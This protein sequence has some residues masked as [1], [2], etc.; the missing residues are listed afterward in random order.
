ME[1]NDF[2]ETAPG[3]V[4]AVNGPRQQREDIRIIR[5]PIRKTDRRLDRS[6]NAEGEYQDS[7][8][9]THAP[10]CDGSQGPLPLSRLVFVPRK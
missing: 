10:N 1:D 9:N 4:H 6:E 2:R 5:S 3:S 8:D 7:N